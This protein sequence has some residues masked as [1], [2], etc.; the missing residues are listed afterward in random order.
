MRAHAVLLTIVVTT[1]TILTNALPTPITPSRGLLALLRLQSAGH[2]GAI[3]CPD[4]GPSGHAFCEALGCDYCVAVPRPPGGMAF[5]CDG[6]WQAGRNLTV[7]TAGKVNATLRSSGRLVK[8]GV[9]LMGH[10]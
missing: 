5:E 9:S 8:P 1:L 6:D 3:S 10:H 2:C 4:G 7:P